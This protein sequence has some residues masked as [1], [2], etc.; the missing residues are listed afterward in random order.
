MANNLDQIIDC[1]SQLEQ[2][3]VQRR[4]VALGP[5]ATTPSYIL[6]S[7]GIPRTLYAEALGDPLEANISPEGEADIRCLNDLGWNPPLPG[8]THWYRTWRAQSEADRLSVALQIQQTLEEAY[9]ISAD[10]PLS[11]HFASS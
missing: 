2:R 4:S 5:E 8:D 9:G 11:I 1:L 10:K 3:A 7:S 6:V